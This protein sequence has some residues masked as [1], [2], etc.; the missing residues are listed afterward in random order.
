M[1]YIYRLLILIV[2]ILFVNTAEAQFITKAEYFFD[3]DPG[4]GHGTAITITPGDT[5]D[6]TT[7]I[8]TTG[9]SSGF[10]GLFIR[11]YDS[12]HK[13]SLYEGR[14]FYIYPASTALPPAQIVKAEYFFDT[15]PGV[16]NGTAVSP[17][18]TTADTADVTTTISTTGLS[19]GFHSL[20][21]R[22][23]NANGKW[24]LYEGRNFYIYPPAS[25]VPPA[26]IVKA[27]Y[28]FDSDPGVGNGTS[29]P[30]IPTADTVDISTT[31]NTTGL[32][33]GFHDLFIRTENT[34]GKW[35]LY[36]GR[37]FYIYPAASASNAAPIVKA[38]YF[39][40]TDPGVGNGTAVSP[41]L[42]TADTVDVT[43]NFNTTGL[44]SGF[45]NLFIRSC[46]TNGKWSLYEGRNFYIY[47]NP[48]STLQTQLVKAEY[49]FDTDPGVGN[50]T[51]V[52]PAFVTADTVDVTRNISASGLTLG[53]HNLF[54]RTKNQLGK[55]SLYEGRTFTVC[56]VIPT[57][58]LGRDTTLC[59]TSIVL[60]AGNPG[61]TYV[62]ST[63]ATTQTITASA[64]N[65]YWAVATIS[66]G[67]SSSD[68]INV[69]SA[70][71][72][73]MTSSNIATICSGGTVVIPLTSNSP[74][75]YNWAAADNPNTTGESITPQTATT[76]G[77]TI[78]N[79]SITPQTVT[80]IATPTSTL[81][82]CIGTAQT[83][84]VTVKPAP[85]MTSTSSTIICDGTNVTIPF[86]STLASSYQWIATDNI[87]TIGE[88]IYMQNSSTLLNT[89]INYATT[90]QIVSYTVT[91]T[92]T[93]YGCVGASQTILVSVT[94][95]PVNSNIDS[96]SICSGSSVSIPFI[97]NVPSTYEWSAIDNL[98][99][100]GESTT[101]QTTG[102]LN[103]TIT[104]N[105]AQYQ[106]VYYTV[107]PTSVAGSCPGTPQTITV[108]LKPG[109]L[110]SAGFPQ[111]ICS[112]DSTTFLSISSGGAGALTYNWSTGS[113]YDSIRVGPA[114][115]TTYTLT[116]SDSI[117][118]TSIS[119]V[120]LTVAHNTDIYGY[121]HY[122]GGAV[123]HGNAVLFN[124]IPNRYTHFDTI[125][126]APLDSYGYYHFPNVNHHT[127][128]IEIFPNTTSYPSLIP[129]YYGYPTA[130]YLWDSST[131]I[132]HG[133]S[134]NDTLN[135]RIAERTTATGPGLLRGRIV[136]GPNFYRN[137][138]D[139]IPGIDVKIGRNPGGQMVTNTTTSNPSSNDGGG[140]YYFPNL[141]YGKYDVYVDIPGLLRDSVY[142][143]Q[144]DSIHTQY[145]QLNYIAD[146]S[147]IYM[148]VPYCYVNTSVTQNSDTLTSFRVGQDVTYQ[149][150]NCGGSV[151]IP[152]ATSQSFSTS[153]PG[154]YLVQ[155]ND[156]GC[157]ATSSCYAIGNVSVSQY[158]IDNDI[159]IAPNPFSSQTAISFSKVQINTVIKITDVL[160]KQIKIA[161]FS[162]KEFILEKAEMSGGI[163]F[164]QIT[165]ENKNVV[166]R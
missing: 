140:Y 157:V 87:N 63:G 160:G 94:P 156:Y 79:N 116:V 132:N 11:T 149:W 139:P 103:N 42:V 30:S 138:G 83:I 91:P 119:H 110:A 147:D 76:I 54:I 123:I 164:V 61:S 134:G 93:L 22:T 159:S 105:S 23:L 6:L 114:A 48:P 75:T 37:N 112:G 166:N 121:A 72:P 45:H 151:L 145:L 104:N 41:T 25:V 154:L 66:S 2:S 16:G 130:A 102:T 135:V 96:A 59:G 49:F 95:T 85:E 124:Y 24:S 77:N 17:G 111:T 10:H 158:N 26:K 71:V 115:S 20:F 162:G 81:G 129:T 107:T 155:I 101:I 18:F 78:V 74:S 12:I 142:T 136:Q 109:I 73:S 32:A 143:V 31:M 29:I 69:T 148:G 36:E 56:S 38:E 165:D 89:L 34:L 62:W 161:N 9:L 90:E 4:V 64:T 144:L 40:D 39:F 131:V 153:T 47:P 28:F 108:T 84:S 15:D 141:Q 86:A 88:S 52:S 70:V 125:Q 99:T 33:S 152:G 128:L 97:T 8:P 1:K 127:Y 67:C 53:N 14:N 106:Q 5:V 3:T 35:S 122:S 133:C 117:G 100:T 13:W 27:E 57:F 82:G 51:P 46:N 118:C 55:W 68:T 60:N 120:I 43:T 50:G 137:L 19:S 44:A 150:Y 80:Y 98:N 113:T 58:S 65:S 146:S 92:S 21:T 126:V 163:Y 7:I